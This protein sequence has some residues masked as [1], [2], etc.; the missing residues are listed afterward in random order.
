MEEWTLQHPIFDVYYLIMNKFLI[1]KQR[2]FFINFYWNRKR[3]MKTLIVT[4]KYVFIDLT[5]N[6]ILFFCDQLLLHFSINRQVFRFCGT[7]GCVL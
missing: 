2:T 3:K 7:F 5:Q 6:K 1:K 4:A